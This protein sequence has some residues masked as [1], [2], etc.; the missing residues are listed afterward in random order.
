MVFSASMDLFA[1]NA[2]AL[3]AQYFEHYDVFPRAGAFWLTACG[4]EADAFSLREA[5]A[6]CAALDARFDGTSSQVQPLLASACAMG[7]PEPLL[8]RV[9]RAYG[10]LREVFLPSPQLIP[11][12]LLLALRCPDETD[13]DETARR[14]RQLFDALGGAHPLL[15]GFEDLGACVLLALSFSDA[16]KAAKTEAACEALLKPAR[17]SGGA[18]QSLALL[19]CLAQEPEA[20]CLAAPKYLALRLPPLGAGALA[21]CEGEPEALA[22]KADAVAQALKKLPSFG[23]LSVSGSERRLWACL[24]T[25]L[26]AKASSPAPFAENVLAAAF[27]SFVGANTTDDL[28]ALR[29]GV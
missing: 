2:Q 11:A 1:A 6:L 19:A 21:A 12:A 4:R 26:D 9:S 28:A 22:E 18:L 14:V 10:A 13:F 5:A 15:T 7:E 27:F 24:L 20:F 16:A 17:V 23:L 25:A 8:L 3:R 29:A